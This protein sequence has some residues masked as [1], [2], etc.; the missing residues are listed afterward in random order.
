MFAA[1]SAQGYVTVIQV[2]WRIQLLLLLSQA[3]VWLLEVLRREDGIE[4]SRTLT[5]KE[6]LWI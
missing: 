6:P 4:Y 3:L 5:L 1:L 2:C